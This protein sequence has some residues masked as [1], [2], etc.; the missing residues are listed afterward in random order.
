M[1]MSD[2]FLITGAN[3]RHG[4]T[5]AHLVQSLLDRKKR[6]RIFVRRET[7]ATNEFAAKG[8]EVVLGDLLDQRTI[9]PALKDV[10]QAYFVYPVDLTI[11]AAAANWAQ[12]VR[13]GAN[14]VRT[15]VMSMPPAQPTHGSPFGRA[16]WLGEQ[17]I[18]WAGINV[19]IVRIMAFFHE[20]LDAFHAENI[21]VRN[22]MRD[23][24][25]WGPISWMSSA[26][27]SDVVLD[28]M[29]HPQK[30]EKP[31]AMVSGTEIYTETEIA[32]MV[33]NFLGRTIRYEHISPE[34]FHK[35]LTANHHP[36]ITPTMLL[37]GPELT[38]G[39]TTMHGDL[40]QFERLTGQKPR[41]MSNYLAEWSKTLK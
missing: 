5:G 6:V 25:G 40:A 36:A 21:K 39:T 35:D 30:Y 14:N 19:Q 10:T 3:G 31:L 29:L 12:A 33:S 22:V 41:P 20:N 17:V 37:H 34:E 4:S 38:P 16:S 8:V 28:A 32:E 7:E 24:Y 13:S 23:A 27:S 2:L 26:D 9:V 15:V 18:Q 1:A 11:T